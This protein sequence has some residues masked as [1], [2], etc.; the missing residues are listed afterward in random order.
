MKCIFFKGFC[1][2]IGIRLYFTH[3]RPHTQAHKHEVSTWYQLHFKLIIL[4]KKI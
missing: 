1:I 4:F 2:D 3:G